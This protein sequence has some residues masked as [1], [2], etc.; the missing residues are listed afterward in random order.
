VYP[1]PALHPCE[2]R[3]T[4]NGYRIPEQRRRHRTAGGGFEDNDLT[5]NKGG[6][7]DI[8]ADAEGQVTRARNR[9]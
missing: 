7:W 8:A 5:G 4:G 6:A 3:A 1:L 9:E 2:G